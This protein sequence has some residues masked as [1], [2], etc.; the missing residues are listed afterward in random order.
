MLGQIVSHYRIHEKLGEGG[1]GVVYRAEDSVLDRQV[2]VK[3]LHAAATADPERR[4]R[5]LHEARTASSLNHPNIVTIYDVCQSNGSDL[6]VMEYV[7]GKTLDEIIGDKGLKV[8]NALKIAIQIAD[9]LAAAHRAGIVHRDLKPGNI[10]VTDQGR[11]KVLDFGLA[12]LAG[13]LRAGERGQTETVVMGRP[14]TMDGVLVGTVAYMSPEQAEGKPVDSRSDVF[15]FG[16]V[17]YEMVT[18]RRAFQGAST[19]S[20]LAAILREQPKP[21]TQ[22]AEQAPRELEK[23]IARC[24]RKDPQ[25]RYQSMEDVK[26][27]LEELKEESESGVLPAASPAPRHA[28]IPGRTL[29]AAGVVLMAVAGLAG[30]WWARRSPA[31]GRFETGPVLSR[32]TFD[33]GL[34]SDP[35]LSP[36]GRLL[37]YASDRSGE[38][39]LDIWVQQLAGGEPLR[40]TR[41]AGDDSQPAFSPDGTTI[42]YRSERDGGGLYTVPTLGGQPRFLARQGRFPRY[43]PD[44]KLISFWVGNPTGSVGTR[45]ASRVFVVR[46]GGGEPRQVATE[47][48][49]A[50]P[51]EWADAKHLVFGGLMPKGSD[52]W[53]N[54]WVLPVEGGEAIATGLTQSLEK[55]GIQ[56]NIFFPPSRRD[57]RR[58]VWPLF[59]A[60]TLDLWEVVL[61]PPEWQY[62]GAAR[63]LTAGTIH[64]AQP[65]VAGNTLVFTAA[66]DRYEIWSIGLDANQGRTVGEPR[67]LTNMGY[68]AMPEVSADGRKL[69]YLAA[70]SREMRLYVRNLDDGKETL[71]A[72]PAEIHKAVFSADGAKV[73]YRERRENKWLTYSIPAAGGV[74]ERIC[75]DCGQL[76]HWSRDGA[77]LLHTFQNPTTIRALDTRTGAKDVIVRH[78]QNN[79]WQ[80]QLS[81]DGRWI[82]FLAAKPDQNKCVFV[83]PFRREAAESEWIPITDFVGENDK[84]RWSPDGNLLYF[85]SDRDGWRCVW[86]R[87]LDRATKRPAGE[88]VG[89]FHAHS[90]RRSMG[91]VGI[92]ALEISVAAG[93]LAFVMGEASGNI[94]TAKLE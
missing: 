20:T 4:Q 94:W 50:F 47:F 42:V 78:K 75:D 43:S 54:V 19:A 16:A 8:D 74:P 7:P 90:A 39:H 21:A 68:A 77:Q 40:L 32:V 29:A 1:M 65:S 66:S 24:L 87:R 67:Q 46:S 71:L 38:E 88:P 70:R 12:K 85:T 6:I 79:L 83:A 36:D 91:M 80:G 89:V 41:D 28:R 76:L 10:M 13:G 51:A 53:R 82:A 92:G 59:Q 48:Q 26:L 18:G 45:G 84:P 5:F 2:A 57:E 81:P 30:W 64:H 52:L 11:V 14:R 86:A 3:A 69:V 27:A 55:H 9:A 34:T 33:V 23:I 72:G 22:I 31:S 93:R 56:M 58:F 25:R 73:A 35:A 17:L 61:S 37:A 15:A 63:R 62:D 49:A 60:D 44:G